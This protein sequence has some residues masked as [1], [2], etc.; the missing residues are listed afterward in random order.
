M[1]VVLKCLE[2]NFQMEHLFQ[3]RTK[4]WIDLTKNGVNSSTKGLSSTFNLRPAPTF[5]IVV[6]GCRSVCLW[7]V[8][9]QQRDSAGV[10]GPGFGLRCLEGVFI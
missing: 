8:L 6:K 2:K 3:G 7:C 9:D 4:L 5:C 10:G 1:R